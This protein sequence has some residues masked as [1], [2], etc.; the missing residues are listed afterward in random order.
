[1]FC[2]VDSPITPSLR[3][4][5]L[6]PIHKFF[7]PYTLRSAFTVC[8]PDRTFGANRF[9]FLV[10]FLIFPFCGRWSWQGASFSAHAQYSVAYHIVSR[11]VDLALVSSWHSGNGVWHINDVTPRRARLVLG[12]VTVFGEQP[13]SEFHR[14]IQTNSASYP[15][16]DGK[17]VSVKVRW[18]S[19]AVE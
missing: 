8:Y 13:T 3:C 2:S 17:W 6:K 4:P 5:R 7:Q 12:W 9:L 18:R 19:A 16:R 11:C 10:L 15:E 14:V 1:M